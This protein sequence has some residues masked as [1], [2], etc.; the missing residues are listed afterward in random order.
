[1]TRQEAIAK[2]QT[3]TGRTFHVVHWE[4][5]PALFEIKYADNIQGGVPQ[6]LRDHRFTSRVKAEKYLKPILEEMWDD[7]EE[8]TKTRAKIA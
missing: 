1:M 3:P 4:V 7:S 2:L 5:N 8:K 6:R